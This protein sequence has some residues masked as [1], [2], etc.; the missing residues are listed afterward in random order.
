MHAFNVIA[1]LN[2]LHHASKHAVPNDV[3]QKEFEN[4]KNS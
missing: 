2:I 3:F 4:K 1:R